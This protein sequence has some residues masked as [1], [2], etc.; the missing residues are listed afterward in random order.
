MA[1]TTLPAD[2]ILA[3]ITERFPA[4]TPFPVLDGV[5]C[6]LVPA[7]HLLAVATCVRD[8]PDLDFNSLMDVAGLDL[9]KFPGEK[10]G[11]FPSSDLVVTLHLHALFHR[12][13]LRLRVHLPRE[14]PTL[15]SVS[16]LWPV[17]NLF[18]R[19]IFD[20]FGVTFTGHPDLRRIMLPEDWT[21]HP[22]RKDYV[23]PTTYGG[24]ELKRDGQQF[25]E[26][27]YA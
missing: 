24:V 25:S 18:E 13:H 5:A 26:G 10:K 27:P 15:P 8:E 6:L 21:G 14:N 20:L 17:A 7:D 1:D 9:V 12:H 22:L 11:E 2:A 4:A 19:E 23:Y 3:R 16:S